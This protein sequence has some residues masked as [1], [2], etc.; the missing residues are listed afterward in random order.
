MCKICKETLKNRKTFGKVKTARRLEGSAI[1]RTAE[2]CQH[3]WIQYRY[4]DTIDK[5]YGV[6]SVCTRDNY[7]VARF[8]VTSTIKLIL[9]IAKEEAKQSGII[10]FDNAIK[11]WSTTYVTSIG[12]VK[13]REFDLDIIR[14][15][16][17]DF[18]DSHCESEED[19]LACYDL[20]DI[21]IDRKYRKKF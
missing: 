12:G 20:T 4:F 14:T 13:I 6:N 10:N 11:K 18:F 3:K 17:F 7:S 2:Q 9:D 1:R 16:C 19:R 8:L 21:I 15:E 5:K